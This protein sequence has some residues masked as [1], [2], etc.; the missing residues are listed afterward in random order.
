[1]GPW[2]IGLDLTSGAT[3]GLISC[4]LTSLN[5]SFLLC[6]L[7]TV[8]ANAH[9][10]LM[11]ALNMKVTRIKPETTL[12]PLQEPHEVGYADIFSVVWMR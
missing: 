3:V 6:Q 9:I 12:I 7:D 11:C 10:G 8:K 1:M 4:I 2:A 5:L